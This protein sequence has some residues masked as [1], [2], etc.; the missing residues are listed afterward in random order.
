MN[1]PSIFL[2]HHE[3][4]NTHKFTREEN[5]YIPIGIYGGKE[6]EEKLIAAFQRLTEET[7]YRKTLFDRIKPFHFTQNKE[8][9]INLIFEVLNG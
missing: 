6:T 9:V 1:I 7:E 3:R 2:S 8:K 4:E 5:G